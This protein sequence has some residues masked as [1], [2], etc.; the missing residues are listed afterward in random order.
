MFSTYDSEKRGWLLQ[1][2][3]ALTAEPGPVMPNAAAFG[4]YSSHLLDHDGLYGQTLLT[5]TR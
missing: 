2:C 1:T 3:F 4:V 5:T